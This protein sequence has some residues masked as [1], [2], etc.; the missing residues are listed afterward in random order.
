MEAMAASPGADS[1]GLLDVARVALALAVLVP[2]AYAAARAV[3][4]P[5]GRPGRALRLVEVLP[6]G[7]GRFVYLVAVGRRLLVLG[8]SGSGLARLDALENPDEVD[9]V[10]GMMSPVR[11]VAGIPASPFLVELLRQGVRGLQKPKP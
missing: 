7:S 10:L 4:R 3:A 2:L 1:L 6:L 9:A 11:A 8:S 5:A